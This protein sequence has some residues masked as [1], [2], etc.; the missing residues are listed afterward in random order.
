MNMFN[1]ILNSMCM[2]VYVYLFIIINKIDIVKNIYIKI[3]LC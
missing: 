3:K 1:K 2:Y